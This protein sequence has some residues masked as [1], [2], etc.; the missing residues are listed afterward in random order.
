MLVKNRL[1]TNFFYKINRKQ[2][3]ELK[4]KKLII[5][6]ENNSQNTRQKVLNIHKT[7]F[8]NT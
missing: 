3:K 2:F 7:E 4:I 6:T 8:E 1:H 5:Y